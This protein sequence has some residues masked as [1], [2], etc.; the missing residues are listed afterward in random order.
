MKKSYIALAALALVSGVASAQSSVTIYGKVDL[1]G[2][3]EDRKSVV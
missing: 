1:G 2:V 3:F